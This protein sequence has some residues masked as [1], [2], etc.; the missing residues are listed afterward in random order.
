MDKWWEGN[1]P[2][3]TI[4]LEIII[5]ILLVAILQEKDQPPSNE[6]L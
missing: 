1:L 3:A 4:S 6:V 2:C 5:I